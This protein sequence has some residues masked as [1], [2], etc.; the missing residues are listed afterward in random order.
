M[1]G[2]L[3]KFIKGQRKKLTT[4]I[5]ADELDELA[6]TNSSEEILSLLLREDKEI[7]LN[8]HRLID[9]LMTSPKSKKLLQQLANH[10]SPEQWYEAVSKKNT[11]GIN[12]AGLWTQ[13]GCTPKSYFKIMMDA[14]PDSQAK[15]VLLTQPIQRN[16]AEGYMSSMMTH[17]KLALPACLKAIKKFTEEEKYSVITSF[18]GGIDRRNLLLTEKAN[19]KTE[20]ILR[21]MHDK[22]L[23]ERLKDNIRKY[24][25]IK[26][27]GHFLGIHNVKSSSTSP[28]MV[29][30]YENMS[31]LEGFEYFIPMLASYTPSKNYKNAFQRIKKAFNAINYKRYKPDT[32]RYINAYREK[33]LIIID[34][35]WLEHTIT[36]AAIDGF[37]I[38]ANRGEGM[39]EAGG[40]II[41]EL[42]KNLTKEDIKVF[43]R[44]KSI[45]E[46]QGRIKEICKKDKK[47]HPIIYAAI[48][49]KTQKYETCSIAN[50]KALIAGLLPLLKHLEKWPKLKSEEKLKI[51]NNTLANARL[52]Y[53]HFTRYLRDRILTEIL[54]ELKNGQYNHEL[55]IDTLAHY[56]NQHVTTED[57]NFVEA[58]L[59]IIDELPIQLH[60][61]FKS[62]LTSISSVLVSYLE[63]NGIAAPFP[64]IIKK[65]TTFKGMILIRKKYRPE[66]N[67]SIKKLIG[68]DFSRSEALKWCKHYFDFMVKFEFY[69]IFLMQMS[70]LSNQE[71]YKI[72]SSQHAARFNKLIPFLESSIGSKFFDLISKFDSEQ[73]KSL[74]T[75]EGLI[76]IKTGKLLEWLLEDISSEEVIELLNQEKDKKTDNILQHPHDLDYLTFLEDKIGRKPFKKLIRD[77]TPKNEEIAWVYQHTIDK[78][79]QDFISKYLPKKDRTKTAEIQSRSNSKE[80]KLKQ[81]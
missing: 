81:K 69:D 18:V 62:K 48:D 13:N 7:D 35:G 51:N 8:P 73:K 38:V 6:Q 57:R 54:S 46:I 49:L 60:P 53:K 5:P 34:S 55:L 66:F 61:L 32:E 11:G 72:L 76:S 77:S 78:P 15:I 1:I 27:A 50:K 23:K 22:E 24:Y 67:E 65:A 71:R 64:D 31:T 36:I 74:I 63:N 40:C 29:P 58:L 21:I 80:I 33:D 42:E 10:L 39:H 4:F 44:R 20:S 41:Y 28:I 14:L 56:S 52:E 9:R 12:A 59:Y 79:S 70:Q 30:H 3:Q 16:E 68:G 2:E 25:L 47:G 37:L 26:S 43:I 19:G 45:E 75:F 17:E